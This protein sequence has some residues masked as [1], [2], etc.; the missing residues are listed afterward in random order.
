LPVLTLFT[1]K[2]AKFP[3]PTDN[4]KD[5]EFFKSIIESGDYRAVIDKLYPLENIVAATKYVETGEK[6]GNV[7]IQI[8]KPNE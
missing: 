6:T 3:I 8:A 7:V 5:I 1:S 2:K 4:K